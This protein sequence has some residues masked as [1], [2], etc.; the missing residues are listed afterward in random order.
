VV[1]EITPTGTAGQY[2]LAP[3]NLWMPGVWQTTIAVTSP[4]PDSAVFSFCLPD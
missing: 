2:T 3:V 1:A 4:T